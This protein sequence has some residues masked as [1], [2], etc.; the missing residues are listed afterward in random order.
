MSFTDS[1]LSLYSPSKFLSFEEHV[2]TVHPFILEMNE[3]CYS[4]ISCESQTSTTNLALKAQILKSKE[5]LDVFS[6]IDIESSNANTN[7]HANEGSE[8]RFNL[9]TP[10]VGVLMWP[11]NPMIQNYNV[12]TMNNA[13]NVSS[14]HYERAI[15]QQN[16]IDHIPNYQNEQRIQQIQRP[17]VQNSHT[18]ILQNMHLY[19]LMQN[20]E[21]MKVLEK[22]KKKKGDF[23]KEQP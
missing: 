6:L 20:F 4:E 18:E 17:L 3:G 7:N 23:R 19:N 2:N 12:D 22:N 21:T 16:I 8:E 10:N 9:Q 14:I 5:P 11:L 15:E 13:K 1:R